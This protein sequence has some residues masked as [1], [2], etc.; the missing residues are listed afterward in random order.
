MKSLEERKKE[1]AARR[2][3]ER[4][5]F[6]PKPDPKAIEEQR[7]RAAEAQSAAEKKAGKSGKAADKPAETDKSPF[8]K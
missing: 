8:A 4:S 1:R 5:V 6:D 2:A 7:M 3:N